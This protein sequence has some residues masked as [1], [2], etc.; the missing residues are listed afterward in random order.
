MEEKWQPLCLS[1]GSDGGGRPTAVC[2]QLS[3]GAVLNSEGAS[4]IGPLRNPDCPAAA[5]IFAESLMNKNDSD[6]TKTSC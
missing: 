5:V 3:S 1:C 4:T 2:A 6:F